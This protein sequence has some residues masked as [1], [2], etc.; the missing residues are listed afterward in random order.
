METFTSFD[1]T[2]IAYHDEGEGPPSSFCMDLASTA[3][4][5][6]EISRVFFR[7]SKNAKRCSEQCL[8]ERLRSRILPS[9]ECRAWHGHSWR[10]VRALSSR[11]C[12]VSEL[13]TNR[14]TK[15][16]T[17]ISAMARDVIALMDHLRLDAVDVIGFSM[18][19]G[20]A[21]SWHAAPTPGEV[22]HSRRHRGLSH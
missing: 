15:A 7:Y 3:L 11:T 21:A 19:S 14:V 12:A 8:G 16:P 10:P 13:R 2:R 18:G 1:G 17:R 20:T 5:S 9:K 22:R 6:T 4:A